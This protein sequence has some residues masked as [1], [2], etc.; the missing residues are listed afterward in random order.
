MIKTTTLKNSP[1]NPRDIEALYLTYPWP[2]YQNTPIAQAVREKM[3]D[4]IVKQ[5]PENVVIVL[6]DNGPIA[7]CI[8]SD[9]DYL[10]DYFGIKIGQICFVAGLEANTPDNAVAAQ[11]L[12]GK[13]YSI[14]VERE[15][16][17][18]QAVIPVPHTPVVHALELY[19]FQNYSGF[20]PMDGRATTGL[21]Y[22]RTPQ[23]FAI[24]EDND[25]FLPDIKKVYEAVSFPAHLVD[26]PGFYKPRR[27]DPRLL[28]VQNF[29]RA[30]K[31]DETKVFIASLGDKFAGAIIAKI[32]S[33]LGTSGQGMGLVVNPECSNMGI[34]KLLIRHRQYYYREEGVEYVSFGA[35]MNNYCMINCLESLGFKANIPRLVFHRWM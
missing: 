23:D 26:D 17:F 4:S 29:E 27:R 8:V 22:L 13:A 7:T 3:W 2:A 30:F 31:S 16:A 10:S 14:I 9:V 21:V 24:I 11:M 19:G 18:V 15:Y 28:Y 20:L 6:N 25:L 35:N 33:E 32:D 34:A 1:I 12:I 5:A